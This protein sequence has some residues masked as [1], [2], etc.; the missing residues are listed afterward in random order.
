[1]YLSQLLKPPTM[2]MK[3]AVTGNDIDV[4]FR[5][6][7]ANA[8]PGTKASVAYNGN[9]TSEAVDVEQVQFSFSVIDSC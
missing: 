9:I 1:M 4:R 6:V 7:F 3:V 8:I 2:T 5:E